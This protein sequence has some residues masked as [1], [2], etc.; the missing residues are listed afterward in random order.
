MATLI[1]L[2][3]DR[4]T[5]LQAGAGEGGTPAADRFAGRLAP[6]HFAYLRAVSEGLSPLDA[7]RRYLQV[8][9]AAQATAA[10]R[11]VVARAQ[12]LARRHADSRWRLL[13]I[14]LLEPAGGPQ[15]G[16]PDLQTWAEENGY[17][18]WSQD[19]LV[20]LYQEHFGS[21]DPR[22]ARRRARNARLRAARLALLRELESRAAA[23]P[24]ATDRLDGWLDPGL[25]AS[26]AA[27]GL[28]TLGEL[29]T[30]IEQGGR[31]WRGVPAYGPTKAGRLSRL[32]AALMGAP[33]AR[34]APVQRVARTGLELIERWLASRAHSGHTARSYRREVARW[35]EWLRLERGK[36]LVE[37]DA[38]DCD[39]YRQFLA[40]IPPQ[41]T[42]RSRPRPGSPDWFPFRGKLS[43]A[44]CRQAVAVLTAFHRWLVDT[45]AATTLPWGSAA[46]RTFVT[47]RPRRFSDGEIRRLVA[48]AANGEDESSARM[49]WL[50]H[51]GSAAGL[52]V[53]ELVAARARNL[54]P[55]SGDRWGISIAPK[56]GSARVV[57]LSPAALRAA[58]TY[59]ALRG[60]SLDTVPAD[61]PLL[62]RLPTRGSGLGAP[63]PGEPVRYAAL[64]ESF[65]R[66]VRRAWSAAGEG[67]AIAEP[68]EGVNLSWL[69]NTYLAEQHGRL[70]APTQPSGVALVP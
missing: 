30:R 12:L 15:S 33:G 28:Q 18:G 31:W 68:P 16:A 41:W 51:L 50:I 61:A 38:A 5:G 46:S 24:A 47:R 6:N 52:R 53:S 13:G 39:A 59:L 44:S 66:F 10:H 64:E 57:E 7:A 60:W 43:E 17:D 11:D 19:E 4:S 29:R 54:R 67:R 3:S 36:A 62:A 2:Q 25:A 69:R 22:E 8:E 65:R 45:R 27:V 49:L 37:A 34:R 26:L 23:A 48:M 21:T 9:R 35:A 20:E 55:L 58:Q 32:V 40:D 63:V 1:Q 56:G 14:D 42:A 70:Q